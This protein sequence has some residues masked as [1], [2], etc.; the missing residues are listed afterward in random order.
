MQWRPIL[1]IFVLAVK[2]FQ[3]E[4][5]ARQVRESLGDR[6]V[7]GMPNICTQYSLDSLVRSFYI[8]IIKM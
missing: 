4:E 7:V 3:L 6:L 1:R 2:L 8:S 5:A